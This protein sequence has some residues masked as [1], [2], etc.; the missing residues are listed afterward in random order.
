LKDLQEKNKE[1]EKFY[2]TKESSWK[3]SSDNYAKDKKEL[4]AQLLAVV[5]EQFACQGVGLGVVL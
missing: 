2:E 1:L 3:S 5:S 4:A